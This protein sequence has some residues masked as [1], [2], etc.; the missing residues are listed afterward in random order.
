MQNIVYCITDRASVIVP[1]EILA[2]ALGVIDH[3]NFTRYL[4]WSRCRIG[5]TSP[6]P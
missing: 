1:Q 5:R 3:V 4:V 2:R 6:T